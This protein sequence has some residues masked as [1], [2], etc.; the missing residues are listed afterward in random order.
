MD[1]MTASALF[2]G[3][4]IGIDAEMS[5]LEFEFSEAARAGRRKAWKAPPN[6]YQSGAFRKY[7]DRVGPARKG[8]VTHSG[9]AKEAVCY[10]EV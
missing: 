6:P 9:G 3:G 10:A 1:A 7:A 2:N 5:T 4:T 8:A